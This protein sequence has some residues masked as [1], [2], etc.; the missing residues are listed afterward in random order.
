MRRR[1]L[2]G[3]LGL[4]ICGVPALVAQRGGGIE[5]H[6][7]PASV[8]DPGRN[9]IPRGIPASVTDPTA[10]PNFGRVPGNFEGQHRHHRTPVSAV[11]YYGY[12]GLP[13]YDY[14]DVS[15]D[16]QAQAQQ[17]PQPQQQAQPQ[18][19]IIREEPST[20]DDES[21]YGEHSFD[22]QDD[23]SQRIPA[24]DQVAQA[25]PAPTPQAIQDD[26]PATTLVYL[27]GHKSEVRNY[28]IV[29]SNLIDLTRSPVLKKIPLASLDLEATRKENEE[30]G[31]DFHTP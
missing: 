10:K 3:V 21:R 20:S 8:T 16:D 9:G 5:L 15:Q 2:I 24:H 29:G 31:V 23:R 18:V 11:P 28:A 7:I 27:D 17:Q 25:R 12:Y 14:S 4:S 1:F 13:Y 30:N 26:S 22:G 6:G 19:I